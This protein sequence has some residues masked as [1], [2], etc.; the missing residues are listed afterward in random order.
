MW[1]PYYILVLLYFIHHHPLECT[2]TWAKEVRKLTHGY[3]SDVINSSH[4][5]IHT[6]LLYSSMETPCQAWH[7][8]VHRIDDVYTAY[9]R[10]CGSIIVRDNASRDDISSRNAT[11]L[12]IVNHRR[13]KLNVT[14]HQANLTPARETCP[15]KYI[16]LPPDIGHRRLL[17]PIVV[18]RP[19]K[20]YICRQLPPS[21]HMTLTNANSANILYSKR[22]YLKVSGAFSIEYQLAKLSNQQVPYTCNTGHLFFETFAPGRSVTLLKAFSREMIDILIASHV[23]YVIQIAISAELSHNIEGFI[24]EGPLK[25]SSPQRISN[26]IRTKHLEPYNSQS[27]NALLVFNPSS[28]SISY[29]LKSVHN[30]ADKANL[31]LSSQA[32]YQFNRTSC[33]SFNSNVTNTK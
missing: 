19:K 4:N 15:H 8:K 26:L 31:S 11:V 7:E 32:S 21:V 17:H 25:H 29:T 22:D 28:V 13:Y 3:V 18:N 30:I 20:T 14:I 27:H 10:P 9:H 24:Y 16:Q 33:Y 2:D 6:L 23:F 5:L 12:K 1:L